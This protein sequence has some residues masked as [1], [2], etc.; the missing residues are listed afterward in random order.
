MKTIFLQPLWLAAGKKIWVY[1]GSRLSKNQPLAIKI[2]PCHV[3]SVYLSHSECVFNF[4]S[5]PEITKNVKLKALSHLVVWPYNITYVF[6]GLIQSVLMNRN[7]CEN[8]KKYLR[9]V[10]DKIK[11][12]NLPISL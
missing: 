5:I 7:S 12:E 8:F 11:F 3:K 1:K 9:V 4:S 6:F 2:C 10:F